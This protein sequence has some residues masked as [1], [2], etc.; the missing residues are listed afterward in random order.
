MKFRGFSIF[1]KR[2]LT[3]LILP[4]TGVMFLANGGSSL[5]SLK[6]CKNL[7][8]HQLIKSSI[9]VIKFDDDGQK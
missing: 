2:T 6:T 1:L 8:L 9:L 3:H 5:C 4:A 7:Q